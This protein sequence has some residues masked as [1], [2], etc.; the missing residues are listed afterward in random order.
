MGV[1]IV[2]AAAIP[3]YLAGGIALLMGAGWLVALGVLSG[4][5]I[6]LTLILTL[7]AV[8]REALR[9]P[10]QQDEDLAEPAR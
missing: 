4:T 9:R 1:T 5:G 2:V 6:A 3:A 10:R 7:A 8:A